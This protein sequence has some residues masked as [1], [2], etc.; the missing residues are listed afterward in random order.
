MST[1]GATSY[2]PGHIEPPLLTSRNSWY[3]VS[4]QATTTID[5]PEGDSSSDVDLSTQQSGSILP[6]HTNTSK[7]VD[8]ATHFDEDSPRARLLSPGTVPPKE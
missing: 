6:V 4:S 3:P 2:R 5:S 8:M 1:G 7:L